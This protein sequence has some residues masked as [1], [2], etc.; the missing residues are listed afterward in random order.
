[1]T[2]VVDNAEGAHKEIVQA[3]E[4]QK[5]TGKWMCWLLLAV[6]LIIGVILLVVLLGK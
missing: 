5:S 1:M 3:Q 4:Y 6:F 2:N